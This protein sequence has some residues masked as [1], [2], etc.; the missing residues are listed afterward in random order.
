MPVLGA[1]GGQFQRTLNYA[2]HCLGDVE[3][4]VL[5]N[6]LASWTRLRDLLYTIKTNTEDDMAD[7]YQCPCLKNLTIVPM[8]ETSSVPRNAQIPS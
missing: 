2:G 8:I 3:A 1:F 5:R 6:A 7:I 4:R